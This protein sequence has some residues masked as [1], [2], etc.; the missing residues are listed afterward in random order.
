MNRPSRVLFVLHRGARAGT[1]TH[2]L[3]LAAELRSRGWDVSLAVSEP[4]PILAKFRE[5]GADVHLVPRRAGNDPLYIRSLARLVRALAPDIVHAHSGRVAAFAAR[6]ARA[7]AILETRHGLGF[8]PRLAT[9]ARLCRLAHHTLT[10][11]E[12]DRARLIRGGLPPARVTAVPNGLRLPPEKGPASPLSSATQPNATRPD[13]AKLRLG[14]LGRMTVQ[15]NPLF[16][17]EIARGVEKLV[18]GRWSMTVGGDG[19]KREDLE[20]RFRSH[21]IPASAIHW[22]GETDGPDMVLERS[23]FL[24]LPSVWEGQPL[25][26]LEAMAT[27]VIPVAAPL[28]CLQ[29]LLGGESPAGLL[30]DL[31]A[32]AWVSELLAMHANPA[33]FDAVA[34]EGRDR[35]ERDHRISSM[36]DRIEGV[37][38]DVFASRGAY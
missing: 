10:V 27:G 26:A 1:E 31:D 30:I 14:F 9:E 7:P 13:P 32:R 6:L 11:C 23:D 37:Y 24:C 3:W 19:P 20:R 18:P 36:A 8:R 28:A 17:A 34:R 21:S 35:V 38:R 33:R 4:G 25:S 5:A 22:M 2:V 29:E 16:L 12:S 15:K